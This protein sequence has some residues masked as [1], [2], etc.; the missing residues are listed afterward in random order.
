MS[1]IPSV[2]LKPGK[3]AP[4]HGGHPWVFSNA[5]AHGVSNAPDPFPAGSLVRVLSF[6]KKELGIGTY[7]PHTNIRVRMMTRDCS[8]EINEEFFVKQFKKLDAWKQKHLPENTNGYRLVHAETDGLPGL[9]VDRYDTTFV[10]QIHTAGMELLRKEIIGAL[11][12]VFSP[13]VIVERSD[14]VVRKR[15]GLKTA[16]ITVHLGSA[17]APV[18]FMENGITFFSDVLK[19]QKTGFFLD[20]RDARFELGK[21]AKGKRGL[22]LFCYTGG[23][24]LYAAKNGASFVTSIDSSADALAMAKKNFNA[25]SIDPEDTTH[26]AFENMDIFEMMKKNTLPHTPYDIIICDPPALAKKEDDIKNAQRA[27]G[28]L[29]QFCLSKLSPGG[30]LIT[31]SCSG[32]I[33]QEDF[34]DT[35]RI[36]AGRAHKTVK[37]L[38]WITQPADHAELLGFDEGRYLKTAIVEVI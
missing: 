14:L 37:I 12:Q 5:I 32:R 3:E 18:S 24:S 8:E 27:Y 13:K 2:I 38:K 34:R 15:E 23:F 35:L 26:F 9:I 36:A 16:P 19:G 6:D 22:N 29:N 11:V 30:I 10:F 7:N 20:Q 31:S 25:N 17:E 33:T 28:E 4:I 21:L 1:T